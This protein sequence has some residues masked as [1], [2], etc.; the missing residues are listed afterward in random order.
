MDKKQA[1]V[2]KH[3]LPGM[4]HAGMRAYERSTR[5]IIWRFLRHR[6]SFPKCIDLLDDE[7]AAAVLRM[8]TSEDLPALHALVLSNNEAVMLEMERRGP[9]PLATS[10]HYKA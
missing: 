9:D 6:I 10:T 4:S 7:L 8:T 1:L 2:A 5:D 3:N